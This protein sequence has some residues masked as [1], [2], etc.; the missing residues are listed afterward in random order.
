MAKPIEHIQSWLDL[1]KQYIVSNPRIRYIVSAYTFRGDVMANGYLRKTLMEPY[2]ILNQIRGD[3]TIPFAYQIYDNYDFLVSKGLSMPPKE[4]LMME[5]GITIHNKNI[6]ALYLA[7]FD[8]FLRLHNLFPLLKA[9]CRDLLHIIQK[10]PRSSGKIIVYRG[11]KD[12]G[13][14]PARTLDYVNISFQSTTLDPDIALKFTK[15]YFSTPMN[16]CVYEMELSM[17]SP[18]LYITPVSQFP[19]EHEILLPYNLR[20]KHSMDI[21]LKHSVTPTK[22]VPYVGD[23][24]HSVS[25]T[26]MVFVRNIDVHGFSGIMEPRLHAQFNRSNSKKTLK[27]NK[28]PNVRVNNTHNKTLRKGN[29]KKTVNRFNP[30]NFANVSGNNE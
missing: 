23:P 30:Y 17:D 3:T 20:Y 21:R 27:S 2:D 15:T 11:V 24:Y 14:I 29:Y 6:K 13:F 1:Q 22:F 19:H 7:N 26:G 8:Y 9:F 5:D 10:A 18:C 12:E 16:F 25:R 28:R 4:T